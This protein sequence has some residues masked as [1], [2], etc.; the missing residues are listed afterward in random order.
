MV[1]SLALVPALPVPGRAQGHQGAVPA[2]AIR[3]GIGLAIAADAG[4]P[5]P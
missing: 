3:N 1:L 4:T 5:G 2:Q